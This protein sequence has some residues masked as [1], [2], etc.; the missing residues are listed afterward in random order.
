MIYSSVSRYIFLRKGCWVFFSF[1]ERTRRSPRS[2][3][4]G[5]GGGAFSFLT[6]FK[7]KT[8]SKVKRCSHQLSLTSY[9]VRLPSLKKVRGPNRI[10]PMGEAR[11]RLKRLRPFTIF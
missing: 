8:M 6:W 4:N 2:V 10:S 3:R 5:G 11:R 7:A 9:I 1:L